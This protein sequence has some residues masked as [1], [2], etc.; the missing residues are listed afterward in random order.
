LGAYLGAS[1]GA[2]DE[3]IQQRKGIER[4]ILVDTRPTSYAVSANPWNPT[5]KG[6]SGPFL[7]F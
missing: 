1:A 4:F 2:A 7:V 5:R 6:P 3:E